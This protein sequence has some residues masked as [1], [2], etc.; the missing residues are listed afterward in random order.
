MRARHGLLVPC[1][2]LVVHLLRARCCPAMEVARAVE[3]AP[4]HAVVD[5]G[6]IFLHLFI[7]IARFEVHGLGRHRACRRVVRFD[8]RLEHA[9]IE[10]FGDDVRRFR[11]RLRL[12]ARD[13]LVKARRD[14]L[15]DDGRHDDESDD[16]DGQHEHQDFRLDAPRPCEAPCLR[17]I[18]CNPLLYFHEDSPFSLVQKFPCILSS[19]F[20]SYFL[21]VVPI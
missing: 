17:K 2:V 9:G 18:I 11:D 20:P 10:P 14:I 15:E 5:A 1:L 19:P 3:R 6:I 4:A 21:L 16:D 8:A 13:L 7:A 12:I